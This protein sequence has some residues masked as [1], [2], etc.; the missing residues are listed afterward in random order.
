MM[1][2]SDSAPKF[3]YSAKGLPRITFNKDSVSYIIIIQNNE[4]SIVGF[5]QDG[6]NPDT[7][8]TYFQNKHKNQEMDAGVNGILFSKTLFK[9]LK[10]RL[11][12]TIPD[13]IWAEFILASMSKGK[14]VITLRDDELEILDDARVTFPQIPLKTLAGIY[15]KNNFQKKL[16][17]IK[18]LFN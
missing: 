1:I 4:L 15:K 9:A 7:L 17:A 10:E 18:K 12:I 2:L 8:K 13:N 14:I 11:D 16:H 5:I 3:G 6:V